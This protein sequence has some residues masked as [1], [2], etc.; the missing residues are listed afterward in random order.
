MQ[1]RH[2]LSDINCDEVTCFFASDLLTLSI[3]RVILNLC[4]EPAAVDLSSWWGKRTYQLFIR[5]KE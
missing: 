2:T 4:R 5:L 3:L 1:G